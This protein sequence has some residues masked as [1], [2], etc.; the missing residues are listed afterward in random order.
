MRY[1]ILVVALFLLWFSLSGHTE[2]LILAL[3]L[4]SSAGVGWLAHRMDRADGHAF[5][6]AI[7]WARL[8]GY[9][10][11]LL[12]EIVRANLN[13]ARI[14]LHPRLPI[15]PIMVPF[16]TRLRS[17][18]C[19]TIYANSITLTPGTLTTGTHGNLLRI[20][21]LTWKDVDGR[22]EDEMERRVLALEREEVFGR[23]AH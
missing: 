14:I 19:R 9:L 7:R 2:P 18:L 11:W 20:H 16:R 23:E 10:V 13:V 4:I 22:E 21:A 15:S 1:L 12:G 5:P 8:P 3:G 6:L 17:A